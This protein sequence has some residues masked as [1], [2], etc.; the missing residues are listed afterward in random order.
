MT[1][2]ALTHPR[3][4]NLVTTLDTLGSS[5]DSLVDTLGDDDG[6]LLLLWLARGLAQQLHHLR[7]LVPLVHIGSIRQTIHLSLGLFHPHRGL[8]LFPRLGL[9]DLFD[10]S[11]VQGPLLCPERLD[12]LFGYGQVGLVVLA[13]VVQE[14]GGQAVLVVKVVLVEPVI[15]HLV[16]REFSVDDRGGQRDSLGS[17]E[18]LLYRSPKHVSLVQGNSSPL[19]Y[20]THSE[21]SAA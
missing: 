14:P 10:R 19:D 4:D 8:H 20:V 16:G 15:D 9:G 3:V 2:S 1:S 5:L 12:G 17:Q 13:L 11:S 21:S 6:D 7:R 18:T